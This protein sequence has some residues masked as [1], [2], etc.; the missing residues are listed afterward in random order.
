MVD[1]Q[2][3]GDVEMETGDTQLGRGPHVVAVLGEIV[4]YWGEGEETGVRGGN[5]RG[6][7]RRCIR[8][9]KDGYTTISYG[10]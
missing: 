8:I 1:G 9:L 5:K 2:K 7:E 3:A 4:W 10:A 6:G